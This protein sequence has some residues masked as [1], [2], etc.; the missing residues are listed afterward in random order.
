MDH[1]EEANRK[2]AYAGQ[3]VFSLA[4][5][6]ALRTPEHLQRL[7]D[8][9]GT[10][11]LP[12]WLAEPDNLS[13]L[14]MA[15]PAADFDL[16]AKTAEAPF[17]REDQVF[18]PMHG[19]LI[20]FCLLQ[21]FQTGDGLY[22]VV[23]TELR[24]SWRE[25]KRLGFPAKKR[26]RDT[27]DAYAQAAVKLYGALPVSELFD[28]LAQ[29]AEVKR[30][31]EAEAL[32]GTLADGTYFTLAEDLVLYRGLSPAEA[33]PY[34]EAR[35]GLP[36]YLPPHDKLLRL[37][38]GDYYDVFHELELWRLETEELLS[39]QQAESPADAATAFV[40]T[41][42]ALLRTELGD[43]DH[44]D[45]FRQFGVP[46]DEARVRIIKDQ[47][48]LWCLYGNTPAELMKKAADGSLKPPVNGPCICG[49]GRKYKRCHG[50]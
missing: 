36:R 31:A 9:A 42:Y 45:L 3:P 27:L 17:L 8:L 22:L 29:R 32:L 11:A 20:G 25:L 50:K 14:L 21:P 5:I 37:G 2:L 7:Q 13:M 10:E 19:G 33:A 39:S 48:R 26:L 47:T 44:G 15:L 30:T 1:M 41:L 49:S 18:L 43:E 24:E 12:D 38:D 6:L 35:Q 23:P 34:L 4:G 40:D 16:F 28:I 46:A